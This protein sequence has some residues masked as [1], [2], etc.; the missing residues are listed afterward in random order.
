MEDPQPRDGQFLLALN[1]AIVKRPSIIIWRL[2]A[3]V[4]R[5]RFPRTLLDI[6][7]G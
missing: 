5:L 2:Q 1:Q 7:V 3:L 4:V 6:A